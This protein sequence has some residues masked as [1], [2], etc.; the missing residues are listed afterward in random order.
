MLQM[1]EQPNPR[2]LVTPRN[3]KQTWYQ[4]YAK[5]KTLDMTLQ[6]YQRT[7][8]EHSINPSN[9][10]KGFLI[11]HD[12]G[13]GK[14][15]TG[16][17][18][19][20]KYSVQTCSRSM[21]ARS[22][23]MPA[24]SRSMP[25]RSR[26]TRMSCSHATSAGRAAPTTKKKNNSIYDKFRTYED[27]TD[28]L[29]KLREIPDRNV[30]ICDFTEAVVVF[31]EAHKL[32]YI[33]RDERILKHIRNWFY[34]QIRKANRFLLLSGTP[35]YYRPMDISLFVNLCASTEGDIEPVIP[36]SEQ[37]FHKLYFKKI[38]WKSALYGWLVPL[39]NNNFIK[40]GLLIFTG[41][42][43]TIQLVHYLNFF[44]KP[45]WSGQTEELIKGKEYP[46]ISSLYDVEK[47][48]AL[49][50]EGT[51]ASIMHAFASTVGYGDS[52]RKGKG[53]SLAA[54][55][56]VPVL[57]SAVLCS[58]IGRLAKYNLQ[59][60]YEL[61][62]K[63]L[64]KDIGKYMSFYTHRAPAV[65]TK[66]SFRR[67]K[68]SFTIQFDDF[69]E[70][71]KKE[72]IQFHR[73]PYSR[74]QYNLFLDVTTG[75]VGKI[76]MHYF[77]AEDSSEQAPSPLYKNELPYSI[78]DNDLYEEDEFLKQGRVIGN[79][80]LPS[81]EGVLAQKKPSISKTL[82][83]LGV[84]GNAGE[85]M[86]RSTSDSANEGSHSTR[87]SNGGATTETPPPKFIE[88]LKAIRAAKLNSSNGYAYA[89]VY[90]SF[91]KYGLHAFYK[92]V[93]GT[94]TEIPNTE[95]G[96]EYKPL[97]CRFY[98]SA[99]HEHLEPID[100]R[101]NND[102]PDETEP[103][104]YDILF[105]DP[106]MTEGISLNKGRSLHVMEPLLNPNAFDQLKARIN[107]YDK[108]GY[109]LANIPNVSIHVYISSVNDYMQRLCL[110]MKHWCSKTDKGRIF[111]KRFTV[112]DQDCTPDAIVQQKSNR[113]RHTI[114]QLSKQLM[115]ACKLNHTMVQYS[116][117]THRNYIVEDIRARTNCFICNPS[118]HPLKNKSIGG[119]MRKSKY[120]RTLS[121]PSIRRR[122]TQKS[123]A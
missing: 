123:L 86:N 117:R 109:E 106:D 71:F 116:K 51:I 2:I 68:E 11:W 59:N 104:H 44:A 82:E 38:F 102:T 74:L 75:I 20:D 42:L 90:S 37:Q 22:S 101:R 45:E 118:S 80:T 76:D 110:K 111:W 121:I 60:I 81:T 21:P 43:M 89:V 24:R 15:L 7:A 92:Y 5:Y 85:L 66:Y 10:A 14:T 25:A 3:L 9:N 69:R 46:E 29:I 113:L 84:S 72:H 83:K 91:I 23:S 28:A 12:M 108:K 97:V 87:K 47:L 95:V 50:K 114:Q 119:T 115:H 32:L 78:F 35:I 61:D 55:W 63:A 39:L 70:H 79:L 112:F 57:T 13:T 53:I 62:A 96:G 65:S 1:S 6:F 18:F 105:I 36:F 26:S 103:N 40:M 31:D 120:M 122:R 98:K 100:W 19:L 34:F 77:A 94:K 49:R 67:K 52:F 73:V 17:T 30:G 56:A 54:V 16:L 64:S 58:V 99:R 88:M 33:M 107:R 41:G 8:V 48:R 4:E 93:M 27:I